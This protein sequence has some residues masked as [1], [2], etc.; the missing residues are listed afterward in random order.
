MFYATTTPPANPRF[1]A[2][3]KIQ[4]KW[5]IE[6]TKMKIK[7]WLM[8]RY[9]ILTWFFVDLLS[10]SEW[11]MLP[12]KKPSMFA[13]CPNFT[14]KLIFWQDLSI[15]IWRNPR[16]TEA[17]VES[18]LRFINILLIS[19]P[20][21]FEIERGGLNKKGTYPTCHMIQ[22]VSRDNYSVLPKKWSGL[23]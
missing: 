8:P 19:M 5:H 23:Y 3:N 17:V 20:H 14:L 4:F 21:I 12:D 15:I 6:K 1:A 11:G 18:G 7:R 22:T 13:P 10:M 2:M 9:M 16:Q